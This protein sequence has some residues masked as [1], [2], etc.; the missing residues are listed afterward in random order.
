MEH[1]TYIVIGAGPAGLQMG[2][3]LQNNRDSYVILERAGQVGN[4]FS[5]YPRHRKLLSINKVY[6]GYTNMDSRLRYDWN[7]LL[8]DDENLVFKHYS[9]HYFSCKHQ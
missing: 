2:F 4:F 3:F 9:Q 1:F 5:K 6:T 8:S 7:S